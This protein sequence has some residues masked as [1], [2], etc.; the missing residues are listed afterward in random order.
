[1]GNSKLLENF[2]QPEIGSSVTIKVDNAEFL[3]TYNSNDLD[4]WG[5]EFMKK[6]S[7]RIK[8]G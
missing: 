5:E 2:I 6:S 3:T 1:M 8:N 4:K 7:Y